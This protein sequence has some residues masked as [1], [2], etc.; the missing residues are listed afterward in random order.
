MAFSSSL[1]ASVLA[2]L[3]LTASAHAGPAAEQASFLT[4]K[5]A[6][7]S[8][9]SQSAQFKKGCVENIPDSLL[10]PTIQPLLEKQMTPAELHQLDTFYGSPL[11]QRYN[12]DLAARKAQIPGHVAA[13]FTTAEQ[14]I[15]GRTLT[16]PASDK[17]FGIISNQNSEFV[18]SARNLL[19]AQI[20]RCKVAA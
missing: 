14:E 16:S 1:V 7:F 2:G 5:G 3:L 20:A 10:A 4:V 18:T 8:L 6:K 19:Q 9:T 15:I 13:S 12:A 11:G 17:Y